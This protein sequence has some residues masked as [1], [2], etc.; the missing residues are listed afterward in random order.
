MNG[1][2]AIKATS[3]L[4]LVR[5]AL[6]CVGRVLSLKVNRDQLPARFEQSPTFFG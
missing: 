5:L 3:S 1:N 2:L 4:D 6:Q